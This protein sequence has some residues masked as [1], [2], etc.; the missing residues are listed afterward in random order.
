MK[1]QTHRD[2]GRVYNNSS[3]FIFYTFSC[4]S[5]FLFNSELIIAA[6]IHK[7]NTDR[8][9]D[10]GLK[11]NKELLSYLQVGFKIILIV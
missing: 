8:K 7:P 6:K 2:A 3:F 10:V 4:F 11:G 9:K 5:A 1:L